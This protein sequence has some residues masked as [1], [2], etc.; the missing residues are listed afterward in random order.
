MSFET[1]ASSA[2]VLGLLEAAPLVL[3]AIGFTLIFRLNGFINVAYSENITLG[4]YFA[5]IFNSILGWNFYLSIIPA[6]LLSGLFS[7]LTYLIVFRSAFKKGVGKTE[8][9]ILS[10]GLS[11][12]I[13]YGSRLIFGNDLFNFTFESPSYLS[14]FGIGI[15]SIQLICIGLVVVI[16]LGLY[17]FIYKTNYGERMRALADNEEL[18]KISGINPTKVSIL[19]WF[20]AGTAGGLAGVFYGAFS[21]ISSSLGWNLILIIIM[22]SIV[23]G[24]GSVRGALIA[25]AGAGIITS[26]V[27][28]LTKPLY[29]QVVLLII[30]IVI[31]KLRK[32]RV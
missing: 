3:A 7:V 23:G 2:L 31:L 5:V 28:L 11:F 1:F 26:A 6:A 30:F 22:V 24:I 15:T 10:V 25:S 19:I 13:W 4:A 18:A 8:L 20:L 9:I 12:F 32:V 21:F 29:G 14:V 27:T 16:S 17:F